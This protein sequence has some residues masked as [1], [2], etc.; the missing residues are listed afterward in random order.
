MAV[1]PALRPEISDLVINYDRETL[2]R[3]PVR[4][5]E[6]LDRF[7]ALGMSR[8]KSIVESWPHHDG[9]LDDAFVDGVLVRSHLELQ[10]LSEEFQQGARI[11]RLLLPILAALRAANVR[12]PYRIVDIG[13]G[14]GY[15]IRWLAHAR[16]LGDDVELTGCDYNARL[17]REAEALATQESL[18]CTFAVTNAFRLDKP[19]TI[20]MSTGVVHHFR[21]GD[22]DGFFAEQAQSGVHVFLHSD[23]KATWLAPTGSWMFH[24]ARMRQPLAR[25]DGIL[26]AQRAHPTS[27]LT[28]AA[29]RGCPDF[30]LGV[31]DGKPEL[32]PILH[33]MQTLIGLRSSLSESVLHHMG[34]LAARVV[35]S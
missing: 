35:P 23:I 18:R 10:R 4:R 2:A 13:C 33:V 22:L 15:V 6:V 26:S 7:T 14:V 25:H 17:V 1:P 5:D 21:N 24:M 32:L 8:A 12:P 20:Y 30:W 27:F 34:K 11:E 16:T 3:L 29:R 28:A 9:Y 19:A 31:F